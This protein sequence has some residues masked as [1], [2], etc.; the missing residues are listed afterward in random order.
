MADGIP[1]R[2]FLKGVFGGAARAALPSVPVPENQAN[3]VVSH[4]EQLRMVNYD[5]SQSHATLAHCTTEHASPIFLSSRPMASAHFT[6]SVTAA[7]TLLTESLAKRKSIVQKLALICE[8][9]PLAYPQDSLGEGPL[10]GAIVNGQVTAEKLTTYFGK[11]N[12][13]AQGML[14][15]FSNQEAPMLVRHDQKLKLYDRI[16]AALK[17]GNPNITDYQISTAL[18]TGS[19]KI[20]EG[21]SWLDYYSQPN[22]I[23]L[24]IIYG[25]PH[26]D[27]IAVACGFFK[28]S[29]HLFWRHI[30]ECIE[31]ISGI[32]VVR[33]S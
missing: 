13:N 1:R 21:T 8:K 5:I 28:T 30:G 19:E 6:Q 17:K 22:C 10:D 4:V 2:N 20:P 3:E 11:L 31:P 26:G 7:R 15:A 27:I 33:Q 25:N 14:E 18:R 32:A 16:V 24:V 9:A 12:D 29:E 23:T